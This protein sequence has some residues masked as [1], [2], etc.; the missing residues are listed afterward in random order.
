MNAVDPRRGKA[1]LS[2]R[3]PPADRTPGWR[4][5]LFAPL[6]HRMLDRIDQGLEQG[7]LDATLPDGTRRM[8][9]GRAPGFD[10]V[11]DLVDW[12]ALVRLAMGGSAGWYRAWAAGEWRS[13]DPVPLFALFMANA[14]SLGR[15]ARPHGPAR[16]AGRLLHWARRNNRNGSRRNIA[17]HYDLGND[18]YSLWLDRNMHYSSALFLNPDD[19]IES[20]ERAQQRKVDAL[21]ERLDLRD[22]QALLE[23]GCGWGGLAEQ[24]MERCAVRYDGLTLSVEQA[25]YARDRLGSGAQIHLTDYRDAQGQY[26]AIASVE[27]V[28]AVGQHYWPD[29]LDAVA[30]L[31]KPGGRAAIQYILIDDA[32]FDHYARGADFIQTY[33]FPGGMLISESRFRTLAQERG[34]EWRDVRHFGDHYAETLRRWRERFDRAIDEGRLPASFDQHFVGLW[35][36]YLMYCEGGFRGGTIDVAQVTLVK[37]AA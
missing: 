13:A 7:S 6:F 30:R 20:L 23:I 12:R 28:E 8:L 29:Y 27:M 18:F 10:C 15:V 26:E 9:G 36:Y 5:R 17:F 37:P 25:D 31:L 34:L 32:I 3:R 2:I 33:I 1:A 16:W 19:R 11:V 22:G 4:A 35:R 21:L 24:A 14:V